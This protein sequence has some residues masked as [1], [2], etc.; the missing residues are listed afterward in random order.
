MQ[1]AARKESQAMKKQTPPTRNE[2]WKFRCRAGQYHVWQAGK[3]DYRIT[4][5]QHGPVVANRDQHGT[6]FSF[7]MA[8]DEMRRSMKAGPALAELA[9]QTLAAAS[10]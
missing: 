1:S 10:Q 9:K 5:G 3:N 4:D 6:A 8:Q 2:G 7:A